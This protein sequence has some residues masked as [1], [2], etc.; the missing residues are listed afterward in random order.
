[1]TECKMFTLAT[2]W[3]SKSLV[4][5]ILGFFL[6]PEHLEAIFKQ[7]TH[8]VGTGRARQDLPPRIHREQTIT[9]TASLVPQLGYNGIKQAKRGG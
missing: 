4:P 3:M 2:G 7:I 5:V 6:V 9:R 8:W 1:M